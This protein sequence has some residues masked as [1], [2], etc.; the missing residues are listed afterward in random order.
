MPLKRTLT[1]SCFLA[2]LAGLFLFDCHTAPDDSPGVLPTF[3]L[4]QSF[5]LPLRIGLQRQPE[6]KPGAALFATALI[7]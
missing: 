1:N 5:E 7:G 4:D 3:T 2:G 6:F